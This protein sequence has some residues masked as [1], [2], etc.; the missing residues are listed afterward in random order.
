LDI[1]LSY[2]SSQPLSS[3]SN[4]SSYSSKLTY[5]STHIIG[6]GLRGN[7]PHQLKCW[8]Y[9]PENNC[10]FYRCTIFSFY[11]NN[12]VPISD[13]KLKTIRLCDKNV[14]INENE[15]KNV[16]ANDE[17]EGPYWSL[18]FEVSESHYKPVDNE[19]IINDTIQGALNTKLVQPNDEI[20]SI[21]YKKFEHGY[22]TPSLDRDLI[23][24]S[25]LPILKKI[26]I[27][28][29]VVDLEVIN[30]KLETRIIV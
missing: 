27:F 16:V 23:L 20:V 10:I 5:S 7:N 30:M 12:N 6:I 2:L 9:F 26:K 18:M 4:L 14:V 11:S 19:N 15:S 21:Y 29:H 17:K 1:T 3:I 13:Y 28:I 24:N 25:T 8:L 22:P